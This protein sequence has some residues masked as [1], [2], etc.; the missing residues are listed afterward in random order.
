MFPMEYDGDDG[1]TLPTTANK[2]VVGI[3]QLQRLVGLETQKFS[4]EQNEI[5]GKEGEIHNK[6]GRKPD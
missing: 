6:P 3:D 2:Q 4:Q 5:D 1:R